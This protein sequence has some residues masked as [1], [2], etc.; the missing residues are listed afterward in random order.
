MHIKREI[1]KT[2]TKELM[3]L[4]LEIYTKKILIDSGK[5]L[6]VKMV[7]R[8]LFLIEKKKKPGNNPN[9]QQ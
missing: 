4:L 1:N 9:I 6:C 2:R 3:I 8:A 7:I 5:D